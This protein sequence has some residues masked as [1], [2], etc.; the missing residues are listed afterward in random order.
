MSF[1]RTPVVS[2]VQTQSSQTLIQS[3]KQDGYKI[4]EL[5]GKTI[6]DSGS[7]FEEAIR[8]LPLDPVLASGNVNWDAFSD[9][10]WSGLDELESARMAILW[11]DCS[12]MLEWNLCEFLTAV[13]SFKQV[14]MSLY[15]AESGAS[16]RITLLLFLM[17]D[18]ANFR[19]FTE[20]P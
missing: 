17:G 8:K 7:F 15:D 16:V 5:N 11:T 9:S 13:D 18:G 20:T 6:K 4:F 10:L 19:P 12:G 14:S 1:D 3:L 2:C